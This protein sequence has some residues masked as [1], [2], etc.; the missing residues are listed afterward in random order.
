MPRGVASGLSIG[1]LLGVF[2]AQANRDGVFIID[3]AGV[4]T[5]FGV[6][7]ST[8]ADRLAQLIRRGAVTRL[9][10]GRYRLTGQSAALPGDWTG[11]AG[12]T[13]HRGGR[14]GFMVDGI[15]RP[16]IPCSYTT[17]KA[18]GIDPVVVWLH[19]RTINRGGT[20]DIAITLARVP[21]LERPLP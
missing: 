19:D 6:S 16:D 2:E 21:C 4:A 5:R 1:R 15:V 8:V 13:V 10:I 18:C 20:G 17:A 11:S 3:R 9:G 7:D 12:Q 14:P